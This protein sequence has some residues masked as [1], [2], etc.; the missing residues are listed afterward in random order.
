MQDGLRVWSWEPPTLLDNVEIP[1][2]KVGDIAVLRGKDK[3]VG[4]SFNQVLELQ[5]GECR[6]QNYSIGTPAQ[7]AWL[8]QCCRGSWEEKMREL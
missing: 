2:S 6:S 5:N 1:W 3:L 4:C 7:T 8:T